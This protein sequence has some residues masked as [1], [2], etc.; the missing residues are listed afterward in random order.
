MLTESSTIPILDAMTEKQHK[1]GWNIVRV[2]YLSWAVLHAPFLLGG[3]AYT[4]YLCWRKRF[5]TDPVMLFTCP[6]LLL[7]LG[8]GSY[9]VLLE[10]VNTV[11]NRRK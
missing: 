7:V 4:I 1:S 8:T 5:W 3:F 6:L 11:R 9:F 10:W 2:L